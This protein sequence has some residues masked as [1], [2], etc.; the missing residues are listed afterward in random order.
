MKYNKKEILEMFES[1]DYP[2]I[3]DLARAY[4]KKY[5]IEYTD[6]IRRRVSKII[7][8]KIDEDAETDTET[9]QYVN[10]VEDDS[11]F[12]PSAW[13]VE[14][15]RF[16]SID[17]YCERFGLPKEQVRSSK[18]V[19]HNQSHMIY[20]IAFNPTIHE[21]TGIDEN[22]IN[23]VVKKHI[24]PVSTTHVGVDRDMDNVVS[25]TFTDVHVGME[26]DKEGNSLY[27]GKWDKVELNN[28]L[29]KM[30]DKVLNVASNTN[31]SALV[32]RD[33]GDL[34]DGYNGQTVR[35]GH[36]L[37]QNMS[38]TEMFDVALDFKVRVVELLVPYFDNIVVHNICNSNHGGD[39][40]YFINQTQKHILEL[41]YSNVEV[42]NHRK[43]IS[44]YGVGNHCFIISHGKDDK[45]V[46]FAFKPILDAKAM[47]KI[48]LYIKN[49]NLYTKYK[50]FHFGKGDSH[51]FIMD[52]STS[53]DFNYFTYPAFSPS[54][55]WVQNNFKKGMSG[56]VVETFHK[57][58]EP[59]NITYEKF[60]WV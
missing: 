19:S 30:F 9:N 28:R 1:G 2:F 50:Y 49:N 25:L 5:K 31:A 60:D 11:V 48:D 16:L 27:G 51:Q 39:F 41:K 44:H 58:K 38:N 33:L 12:M 46:R 21:Q 4:C 54:S 15:G 45:T 42:V 55:Q 47:E 37:P 29:L 32:I 13:D 52:F 57:E 36:E 8:L 20:N 6:S 59:L 24:S 7:N 56:F 26:P 22:F 53:Q 10:D 40:D 17:E 18:L 3:S 14:K 35:G 34:A 23:E 43:F